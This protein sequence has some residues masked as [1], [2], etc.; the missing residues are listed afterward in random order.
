MM[1][2][3]MIH[4]DFERFNN[5]PLDTILECN[6]KDPFVYGGPQH[7]SNPTSKEFSSQARAKEYVSERAE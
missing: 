4:E 2:W 5:A 6:N 3:L 7:Y 1:P